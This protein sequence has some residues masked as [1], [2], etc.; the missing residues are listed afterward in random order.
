MLARSIRPWP[1]HGRISPRDHNA[2]GLREPDSSQS[3][4]FSRSETRSFDWVCQRLRLRNVPIRGAVGPERSALI[5]FSSAKVASPS[6]LWHHY[7]YFPLHG[8]ETHEPIRR[9][10]SGREQRV[11]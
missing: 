9:V 8:A 4:R 5:A 3:N 1:L 7:E 10:G 6:I 11:H 2:R